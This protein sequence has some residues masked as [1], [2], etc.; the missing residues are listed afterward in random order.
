V[1]TAPSGPALRVLLQQVL[2]A[3]SEIVDDYAALF[4]TAAAPLA[5]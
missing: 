4:G 3:Q 5:A 1:R 2:V